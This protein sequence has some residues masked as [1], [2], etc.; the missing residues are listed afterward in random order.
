MRLEGLIELLENND[1]GTLGEDIFI[2]Y[3]PD[4]PNDAVMVTTY[5]G[6]PPR[7]GA[8]LEY[9]N[10]RIY[11]RSD[12]YEVARDKIETIYRLLHGVANQFL[13]N[14]WVLLIRASGAPEVYAKDEKNRWIFFQDYQ[15]I[16]QSV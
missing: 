2:G 7:I 3:M 1:I 9:P 5:A 15:A 8:P 14:E 4:S 10:I 6:R 11:V 13:G 12:S 16:I